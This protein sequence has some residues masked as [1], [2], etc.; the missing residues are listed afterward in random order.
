MSGTAGSY[1]RFSK[2]LKVFI[3]NSSDNYEFSAKVLTTTLHELRHAY[4]NQHMEEEDSELGRHIKYYTDH[5]S[6]PSDSNFIQEVGYK[7]NFIEIDAQRFAFAVA[8]AVT[9]KII[10][11]SQNE[12]RF[13]RR[14]LEVK[15]RN[16]IAEANIFEK[17]L[18]KNNQ[19]V[20][21][22]ESMIDYL[23]EHYK[24]QV[25]SFYT[26]K[27]DSKEDEQ[28]QAQLIADSIY[29]FFVSKDLKNI[30]NISNGEIAA[31]YI[32]LLS[33]IKPEDLVSK[34]NN[35][36]TMFL[37]NA[38]GLFGNRSSLSKVYGNDLIIYKNNIEKLSESVE[39]GKVFLD[40]FNIG[41]NKKDGKDI[42]LKYA[43][44]SFEYMTKLF[45]SQVVDDFDRMLTSN[46]SSLQT[47]DRVN[48][49]RQK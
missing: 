45:G 7:T 25:S 31:F 19:V 1:D 24:T 39:F 4:Q 48:F 28:L 38:P 32:E 8:K 12:N 30:N 2:N 49:N 17:E 11:N 3:K 47:R 34:L 22:F 15:Y 43:K 41:Y 6:R 29:E 27:F 16:V 33:S 42:Y 5:Y 35:P 23:K 13:K 21:N 10:E 44:Y 20:S 9:E 40:K 18:A 26:T 36:L 14:I 37:K 46:V